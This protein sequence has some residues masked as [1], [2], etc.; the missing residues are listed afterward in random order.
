MRRDPRSGGSPDAYLNGQ[1]DKSIES[2]LNN[3]L[4]YFTNDNNRDIIISKK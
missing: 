1:G 2:V 3:V 4:I